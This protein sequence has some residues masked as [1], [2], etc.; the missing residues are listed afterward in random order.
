MV[1][2]VGEGGVVGDPGALNNAF[3][4]TAWEVAE[5]LR[6][7]SQEKLVL[8]YEDALNKLAQLTGESDPDLLV[9]KYLECEWA[10]GGRGGGVSQPC[11][12]LPCALPCPRA[13][14]CLQ[15]PSV[16]LRIV[17]WGLPGSSFTVLL[18]GCHSFTSFVCTCSRLLCLHFSALARSSFSP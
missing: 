6:K 17:S 14:P 5:G 12:Y 3:P 4:P 8:R 16:A 11:L 18:C 2:S 7:T 1:E 9:E 10:Q 13:P 15:C